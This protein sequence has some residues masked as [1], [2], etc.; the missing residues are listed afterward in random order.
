MFSQTPETFLYGGPFVPSGYHSLTGTFS[1]A[2]PQLI[3][4]ELSTGNNGTRVLN[5]KE[6]LMMSGSIPNPQ[7]KGS[8]L[9][10]GGQLQGSQLLPRG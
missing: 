10:P 7:P 8:Q 9:L 1:G 4:H 3:E 5:A 2:S 6:I